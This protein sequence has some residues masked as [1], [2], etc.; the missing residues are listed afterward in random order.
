MRQKRMIIVA[1]DRL[2]EFEWFERS[3]EREE[4]ALCGGFTSCQGE[5]ATD[6]F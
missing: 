1:A 3:T 5:L 6:R 4:P 2:V